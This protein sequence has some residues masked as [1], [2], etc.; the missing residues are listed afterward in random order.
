MKVRFVVDERSI[1]LNGL[2]STDGLEVIESLLE[3]VEDAL[4]EG[5]GTCFDDELFSI[6]LVSRRSFW[7][8]CDPA[9][10]VYL[11]PEIR[12][13]AAA[14]FGRMQR[15]YEVNDVQLPS[16]DVSVDGGAVETT[17]SI[18]GVNGGGKMCQMA[19]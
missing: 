6:P 10:P 5:Y 19:A 3:R 12:Q 9:S 14:T 11:P 13:R 16:V 8:L 18:A 7:E 1:D 4:N 2:T 15:W 17:A